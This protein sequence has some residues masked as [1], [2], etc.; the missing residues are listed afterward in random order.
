MKIPMKNFL[1]ITDLDDNLL[2]SIIIGSITEKKL[3]SKN[4]G[5]IY[6]LPSTRT[7]LSFIKAI[8]QLGGNPIDLDLK[9]LNLSR[10][11]SFEDTF[12]IFNCYLDGIVFRTNS[13]SKLIEASKYFKYP[14]INA[15]SEISHPCQVIADLITL[16]QKFNSLNFKIYWFGDI[17]NVCFS[18]IEAVKKISEIELMITSSRKIINSKI[19]LFKDTKN[20]FVN[21]CIDYKFLNLTDCVMTD[22]YESMNDK[23]DI[24]KTKSLKIFKVDQKL[25]SSTKDEC[26]FM[27]CLPTSYKEVDKE[28]VYGVKSL[29]FEQANNRTLGQLR[30]LQSLDW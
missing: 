8:N 14:I 24:E 4:I 2:K 12:E 7:R 22:V 26:V 16:Y 30:V 28:V 19:D 21:D 15:L 9:T 17:N 29:V 25:M 10:Y 18:L 11:E 1:N 23:N 13:H 3:S 27:H 6:E 5:C 20:I